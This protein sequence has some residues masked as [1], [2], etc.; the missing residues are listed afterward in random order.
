N[1]T[2]KTHPVSFLDD[3]SEET[4]GTLGLLSSYALN[5]RTAVQLYLAFEDKMRTQRPAA[6]EWDHIPYG[7]KVQKIWGTFDLSFS[8]IKE[9]FYRPQA[10]DFHREYYLGGDFVGAVGDVGVYGEAVLN[11]PRNGD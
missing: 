7:I 3:L 10:N 4:P 1:P 6:G 9:V 5:D 11:L 2:A 8:W